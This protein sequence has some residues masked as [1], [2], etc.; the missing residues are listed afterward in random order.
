MRSEARDRVNIEQRLEAKNKE[1]K[2]LVQ[3]I[4]QLKEDLLGYKLNLV[5][6][7]ESSSTHNL[8][9]DLIRMSREN[10]DLKKEI[11]ELRLKIDD[12]SFKHTN[13]QHSKTNKDLDRENQKLK[14]K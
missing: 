9:V 11:H 6:K 4:D 14:E 2:V 10:K 1:I 13:R 3:E 12:F 8:E 7:H 5:K